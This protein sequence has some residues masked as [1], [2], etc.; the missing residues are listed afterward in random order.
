MREQDGAIST[1]FYFTLPKLGSFN[2]PFFG[3][4]GIMVDFVEKLLRLASI[5]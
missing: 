4:M 3:A 5:L 2:E 1:E